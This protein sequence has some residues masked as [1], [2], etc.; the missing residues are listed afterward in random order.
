MYYRKALRAA[1]FDPADI[2]DAQKSDE[3]TIHIGPKEL[4]GSVIGDPMNCAGANACKKQQHAKWAWVG[5]VIAIVAFE[6]GR[7]LRY[8]HN[9][10]LPKKHDQGIFTIGD[11]VFRYV[12]EANRTETKK[13]LNASRSNADK[14]INTHHS[15]RGIRKAVSVRPKLG[16]AA[17]MRRGW[18]VETD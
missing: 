13:R 17:Q 3:F 8:Q 9:G 11:Y 1:G 5:A 12:R 4:K 7:L 6:D 10:Q 18:E 2:R 14:S 15:N 16:M